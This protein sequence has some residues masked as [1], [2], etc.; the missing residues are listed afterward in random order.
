[1]PNSKISELKESL[2]LHSDYLVHPFPHQAKITSLGSGGNNASF[3]IARENLSNENISYNHLKSSILDKSFLL[4]GKQLISGGK[5]FADPC[6]FLSRTNVNEV[7][8][9]TLTGDISGNVFVGTSGLFQNIG[10]S[11]LFHER[12]EEPSYRLHISGDSCFLGDITHTGYRR[13]EGDFYRI[14]DSNLLGDLRITG[15]SWRFGDTLM[16]GDFYLTGNFS[17]TGDRSL[18]GNELILGDITHTGNERQNGDFYKIGN[19]DLLGEFRISGDSWRYGD[20]RMSGDFS[21]T[22]D[23]TQ[24]GNSFILGD[25]KTAGDIH[26]GEYIY[27]YEDQDTFI[28]FKNNEAHLEAGEDCK[29]LLNESGSNYISLFT[30]GE[31]HA[32][33]TNEGLVAINN[34][35]PIGE[36]S[37]TGNSFLENVFVYDEFSKRFNK[38]FGGNDETVTF[39]TVIQGGL[40]KYHV[41]LPKTFKE[42]PI[43]N[44]S[45]ENCNGNIIVPFILQDGNRHE[46]YMQFSNILP[47]DEYTVH[48]TAIC[49]SI[50]QGK[51]ELSY[52]NFP[53]V[54]P[55]DPGANRHGMQR[56]Y[57]QPEENKSTQEIS[58]PLEYDEPPNISINMEGGK[59]VVPYIISNITK[60]SFTLKLGSNLTREH[61]IHCCTSTQGTHRLGEKVDYHAQWFDDLGDKLIFRT[62]QPGNDSYRPEFVTSLPTLQLWELDEQK[63]TIKPRCEA[64]ESEQDIP[65]FFERT[66]EFLTTR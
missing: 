64:Q 19:S 42:K 59:Y 17:Q 57:F 31:E 18:Y 16:N 48:T 29:I 61:T 60:K 24:L 12:H 4:T 58:F 65:Q 3:M 41:N 13:Q 47:S 6:T 8:D 66:G 15:D 53:Y 55:M 9:N 40:D 14:G 54:S 39:K 26:V 32:R 21:I 11:T 43:L 38:V 62:F 36:L 49:S 45:V 30:S 23:F 63:N 27:H 28:Q 52:D 20:L 50:M 51:N 46:F 25:K 7:L 33:L 44:V 56:F 5:I 2:I 1:M 10:V 35:T 34:K 22:G 37:V